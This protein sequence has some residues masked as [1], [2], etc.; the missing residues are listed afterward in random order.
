MN[1][2]TLHSEPNYPAL[3]DLV[4]HIR[5]NQRSTSIRMSDQHH[6]NTQRVR[7]SQW[8]QSFHTA[9]CTIFGYETMHML[10]KGQ[11]K[12]M[13]ANNVKAQ[14]TFTNKLFGLAA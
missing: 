3:P 6:Q 4:I 11:V 12:N 7:Q 8:F 14:A 2:S 13:A 10:R 1:S 5:Q 9:K